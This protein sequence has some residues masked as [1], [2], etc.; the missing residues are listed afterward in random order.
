ML[1]DADGQVI[2]QASFLR[3]ADHQVSGVIAIDFAT[4]GAGFHAIHL[5]ANDDPANGEGCIA[6]PD[7][8]PEEHFL[9]AD[10]HYNPDGVDHG[11]HAGDLPS[12]RILSDG[13]GFLS[14]VQDIDLDALD[15]LALVLHADRDNFG[16]VPVG[17]APDDYRPNSKK[18]LELT[19]T[20][21]H[22]GHRIAC[23]VIR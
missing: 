7:Q 4:F 23:G 19:R 22:T 8:P 10:D 21:G 17:Q 5:H 18:A 16:H 9:S 1:L 3:A 20:A 2:G 14:F 15:G 12:V 6:D 11:E 13:R